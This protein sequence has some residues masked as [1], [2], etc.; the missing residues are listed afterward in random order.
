MVG[1][2]QDLDGRKLF[3]DGYENRLLEAE[4]FD[5]DTKDA[6]ELGAGHT[7]TALYEIKPK[8][9]DRAAIAKRENNEIPLRY[10]E[11]N[12]STEMYRELLRVKLR[13][14]NPNARRSKL[15][16]QLVDRD[17]RPLEQSSDNFRFSAAVTGF[18]LLLKESQYKGTL[19]YEQIIKLAEGASGSTHKSLPVYNCSFPPTRR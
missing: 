19:N 7:V 8:Y 1:Y 13:Y 10:T 12:L 17:W 14:K 9:E 15:I 16:E 5:D 11:N 6:G 4:D 18:S 3:L 2:E